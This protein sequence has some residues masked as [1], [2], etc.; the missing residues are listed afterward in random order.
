MLICCRKYYSS[1]AVILLILLAVA[2]LSAQQP[3]SI[4]AGQESQT[5]QPSSLKWLVDTT[6]QISFNEIDR[7][8]FKEFS[9]ADISQAKKEWTIWA[10]MN[11]VNN[12]N[13]DQQIILQTGKWGFFEAYIVSTGDEMDHEV[14]GS[15]VKLSQRSQQA[16]TN[17]IKLLLKKDEPAK[18][19]LKFRAVYS[20]YSHKDINLQ[21]TQQVVFEKND[22]QR[23]L[24][25]G[26]FFGIIWVM[27]LYNLILLFAVKDISYL[28][29]V[30][31]IVSIGL[32]F[33]FYYGFGIE[34]LWLNSPVWD[35]FCFSIINPFTGL[36]RILFT[37]TYLHT[38]RLL[39]RINKAMNVLAAACIITLLFAFGF[40]VMN[41]DLLKPL[42]MII[43]V[44]GAL[45][46]IMMLVAGIVAYYYDKYD[47]AKFFIAANIL[48]VLGAIAFILRETGLMNDNFISRY[49]VQ[50]GVLIQAV[51]LSLGLA[52]RL[53]KMRLKLANE[54]LEKERLAFETER[55]KK[56]LIEQQKQELQ[57]QVKE[58]TVD[59][60]LKNEMLEE[61]IEQVKE[62]ENK[63]SQLNQVKD[64]LFSIVSHDLRNP[65]ATMQSFLKLITE[66]HEKLTEEERVKL[67]Y[68]AQ[69]S[70]DN[71]NELL[72]NLLQ[73]SKSQMNLLQFRRDKLNIKSI[74]DT[75]VRLVQLHAHMK[76]VKISTNVEV[77]IL[78]YADKDMVEFVI[79]NLLSN[80]IKFS[81]RSSEVQV[82]A[83]S[84]DNLIHLEVIDDGIGISET[85]IKKLL[86]KNTSITRRGTEKEKGTGLG[87]LVSKEFIEKNGGLL[88][89]RS[90]NGK[91][92]VFSFSLPAIAENEMNK[93]DR[94]DLIV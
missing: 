68:E 31:S 11:L 65:L 20:I 89:I 92:S 10:E 76:E 15:L 87:L 1:F 12:T 42:V 43:G 13:Q 17:A 70:L 44:L 35:T 60:Q 93:P 55:E 58:K 21:L 38:P 33:G 29:Y 5:I 24:W 61:T 94:K 86:E 28:Y 30:L 72:Y 88:Q 27:G 3:V 54:T 91:G 69:Q 50:Y 22:R 41:I 67:F 25:Q 52:S 51:V 26:L 79:R 49:L 23:L 64:K 18:L 90:E 36:T 45:V 32:Y 84:A 48:L 39:P 81:H 75:S 14:S 62:S 57:Q 63:L 2:D 19:Y 85:K 71:L 47:P 16:N 40:Y 6:G 82:R 59:L 77:G 46:L 37:R 83:F 66:H 74:V 34:Y 4:K 73:W 78:A 53:N 56:R 8:S 80:A 9:A 7:A